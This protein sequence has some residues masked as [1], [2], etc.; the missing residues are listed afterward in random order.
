MKCK[1]GYKLKKGKCQRVK[2]T[3]IKRFFNN[4]KN[5]FKMIGPYIGMFVYPILIWLS[6]SKDWVIGQALSIIPIVLVY[7]FKFLFSMACDGWG[8]LGLLIIA[9]MIA[10]V[11]TGFAFGW[12]IQLIIRSMKK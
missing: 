10:G 2:E 9:I 11:V 6:I 8:C 3:K 7:P 12:I 1:K 5:P 4:G